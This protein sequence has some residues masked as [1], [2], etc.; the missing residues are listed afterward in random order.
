MVDEEDESIKEKI[1]EL[2][3]LEVEKQVLMERNV[4]ILAKCEKIKL[5]NKITDDLILQSPLYQ[6]LRSQFKDL[7][8][9]TNDLTLKLNKASDYLT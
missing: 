2:G 4:H 3:E 5:Q 8:D 9:Y 6:H 7:I 1:K